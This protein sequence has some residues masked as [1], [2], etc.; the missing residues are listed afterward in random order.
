M[1]RATDLQEFW[2]AQI[3]EAAAQLAP[4]PQ[5]NT[6]FDRLA[7]LIA[8]ATEADRGSVL[9]LDDESGRLA[10]LG[11]VGLPAHVTRHE[12]RSPRR[13]ISDWVFREGQ[14]LILQGDARREGFEPSAN[15]DQL[16]SAMSLPLVTSSGRVGVVN[17][18]RRAPAPP[19]AESDLEDVGRLVTPVALGIE[20]L[21]L[22][23]LAQEHFYQLIAANSGAASPF[24]CY[25]ES[26]LSNYRLALARR[27]SHR[28]GFVLADR[29]SHAYGMHTLLFLDVAGSGPLATAA[30]AFI[31]GQFLV[32]ATANC[33]PAALVSQLARHA[34][35]RPDFHPN[36]GVW[37]A[38]LSGSG[39]LAFATAGLS[40][41]FWVPADGSEMLRLGRGTA[42][43][44][45]DR[46]TEWE[47]GS[48]RLLP[49]DS[50]IAVSQGVL[51]STSPTGEAF[52]PDRLTE[53]LQSMRR[54]PLDFL[55]D[56]VC[57]AVLAHTGRPQPSSDL[58]VFAVRFS[59]GN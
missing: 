53:L 23:Q 46:S 32:S 36:S 22:A 54:R 29:V 39:N 50:V 59:P 37:T 20:R 18:A 6:G 28:I 55:A 12:G 51:S 16:Q 25:G 44:G 2:L 5:I 30:G 43:A 10:L 26:T 33:S 56:A 49:G 34:L 45:N 1:E 31:H 13:S 14:P 41:P 48:V 38:Q 3:E 17:V 9:V 11:S 52:G 15:G 58:G 24:V 21:Q 19:F 8:Q 42:S 4:N 35:H 57:D 27:S 40:A 47:E 7:E